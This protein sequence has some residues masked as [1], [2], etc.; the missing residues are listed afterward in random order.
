MSEAEG[1]RIFSPDEMYGNFVIMDANSMVAPFQNSFNLDTELERALPGITP[2]VPTSVV[3]ELEKLKEKRDWR[4]KAALELSGK[5]IKVDVKGKG[6]AP[7]F[8]LAVR[9]GWPVM[10]QDKRLRIKLLERGIPVVI[11]KDRGRL[12][13]MEP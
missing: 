3:R 8:N 1:G 11:I 7:I 5:Y 13:L 12:F 2:V 10:T 6:D 4:I 9:K